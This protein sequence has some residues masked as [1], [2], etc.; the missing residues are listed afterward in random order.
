M[1]PA[2]LSRFFHDSITSSQPVLAGRCQAVR[3]W[4]AFP[5][6]ASILY[7]GELE[8]GLG[9]GLVLATG[10]A[11][12]LSV[13]EFELL[14][15]MARRAGAIV[16]RDELYAAVWGGELRPGDRSVD[17]YVS[18][19]RGKLE[20][21]MPDRRFIHTHPGFGYRFQPQPRAAERRGARPRSDRRSAAV[22][23]TAGDGASAG[24]D[25]GRGR[26]GLRPTACPGFHEMFT[27]GCPTVNRLAASIAAASAATALPATAGNPAPAKAALQETQQRRRSDQEQDWRARRLSRCSRSASPHAAAAQ[28]IQQYLAARA[29]APPARAHRAA[30]RDDLGRRF[31]VRGA[32]LPAVGLVSV[33][34]DGQ[35][36]GRR[37]GR[38]H[39]RAREQDRRLRCQRPAAEA[40]QTKRRS[41]RTAARRCRSR[42]SSAR[43]PSPTT[44][45]GSRPA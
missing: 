39:H 25:G 45:P 42:C 21:A 26:N 29:P 11:L 18:K 6:A 38:G 13:R 20:A 16:T 14:A 23:A 34:P 33:A 41:P 9:E 8:I 2:A 24:A 35:L 5:T 44:C 27:S 28:Q 10:R 22:G 4:R 7:A 17:V 43:S 3:S 32:R 15:A 37:L 36:P 12:T 40:A 19:L 31:D 1:P 30:D